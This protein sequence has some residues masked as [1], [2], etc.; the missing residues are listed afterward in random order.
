[1]TTPVHQPIEISFRGEERIPVGPEAPVTVRFRHAAGFEIDVDGFWDGDTDYRVRFLPER[2]GAWTW[3]VESSLT[4]VDGVSGS[5]EV[6]AGSGHGAVRVAET[7]HF[8]HADGTPFR[9]V[10]GTV[11]N[12][13]HQNEPLVSDTISSFADAGLNKL[14]FMVFPQAGGS[15]EHAPSLMP[16]EK[17]DGSWDVTRPVPEF[18][19]RLDGLVRALGEAGIEADVLM[20]NAYD[21]GV[22]GLNELT[23]AEDEIYTRYLVA[24]LGAEPNVWWSLCNE[25]DQLERSDA[26]WDRL[27]QFV[28]DIDPHQHPR[29]IHNWVQIFDH[30]RPWVTHASIQNGSATS[31]FGRARLYRDVYRK[32]IVLDEIKYE[33]DAQARWGRLSA[34]ELVDRFWITTV[35]G[36]YA[37]HGESFELDDG[38]LHIVEGGRLQGESPER[39][40]F[41]RSVLDDLVVPGLDPIDKWEDPEYGAGWAP[42]QY[43]I[44]LGSSAPAEWRIRIPINH[45]A[46]RKPRDGDEY[47][48]DVIDTWN[49]TI[50]RA[51]TFALDEVHRDEAFAG[52]TPLDLAEGEA[53][54]IRL[55][56]AELVA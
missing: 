35:E 27:G 12:W 31:E 56:R 21:R 6:G 4:D 9:P 7:F 8:A 55:T 29:S 40:G 52:T 26:R 25:Y 19:Q 23:E 54:A 17:T 15:V 1:M 2:E 38:S 18:F 48:V 41:L 14:R 34:G 50:T 28:A 42:D 45:A 11:Y 37:S 51:G 43:L 33:G 24:R 16:F 13:I 47:V 39:L 3:S 10:G 5:F 20:L 53:L 30:N 22:F 44:Y 46:D 49:M 32:P 36:C